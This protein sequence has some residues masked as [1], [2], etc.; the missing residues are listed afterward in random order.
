M[1]LLAIGA[2]A[3]PTPINVAADQASGHGQL[4][5]RGESSSTVADGTE[6]TS[7][8]AKS[9]GATW[10]WRSTDPNY[11]NTLGIGLRPMILSTRPPGAG[12]RQIQ[13][14]YG[15]QSHAIDVSNPSNI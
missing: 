14:M 10:G 2:F 3:L 6:A 9:T 8:I 7:P 1:A 4:Q 13:T 5:A 12:S 15:R 11:R